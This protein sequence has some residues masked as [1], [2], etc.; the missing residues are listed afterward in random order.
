MFF[1]HTDSRVIHYLG[2]EFVRALLGLGVC[3][4]AGCRGVARLG[5]GAIPPMAPAKVKAQSDDCCGI[6]LFI[7][8]TSTPGR[9]NAEVRRLQLT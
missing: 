6:A 4:G 9:E 1:H 3:E 8:S 7:G 2:P 5:W